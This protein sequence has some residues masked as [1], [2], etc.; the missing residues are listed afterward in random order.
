MCV[1]YKPLLVD[2]ESI[3]P[4]IDPLSVTNLLTLAQTAHAASWVFNFSKFWRPN[5]K[6]PVGTGQELGNQYLL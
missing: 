5:D 6:N 2:Q 1:R 3:G 4:Q